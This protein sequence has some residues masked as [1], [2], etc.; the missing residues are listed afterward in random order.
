MKLFLGPIGPLLSAIYESKTVTDW[1]MLMELSNLASRLVLPWG[2]YFGSMPTKMA[3]M[4]H[5]PTFLIL[6]SC[7]KI[8]I[9]LRY[10]SKTFGILPDERTLR[11]WC[12]RLDPSA[13]FSNQVFKYLEKKV[14]LS[15]YMY[16][17]CLYFT[18]L[19]S[20]IL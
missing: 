7:F 8:S 13:G 6:Q 17:Y 14:F 1:L 4:H 20:Q 3:A 19:K 12:Q 18:P 11:L 15:L 10:L 16:S 2:E 9:T 5:W